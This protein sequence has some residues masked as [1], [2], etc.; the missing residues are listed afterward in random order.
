[1]DFFHRNIMRKIKA[2]DHF[3]PEA[4]IENDI[5]KPRDRNITF[6]KNQLQKETVF[7]AF[8]AFPVLTFSLNSFYYYCDDFK[9]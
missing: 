9:K 1:M 4:A 3:M 5:P 8:I 6:I 2:T 7:F